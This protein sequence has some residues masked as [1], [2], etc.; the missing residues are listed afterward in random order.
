MFE[1]SPV[2]AAN[3][4]SSKSICVN[5]GGTSS[6]KTYSIL[7]VIFAIL[8]QSEDK[9]CT[10]VGQDIPNLKS[11]AL[12]D[13]LDIYNKSEMLKNLV[14][15]YNKTD[16]IFQFNNGSIVEFKSY[17]DLQDAKS[18]KR[19]YLFV[20]EANGIPYPVYEQ[21]SIRTKIR[22][23]IDYNPNAE[24]W[25]HEH[26]IGK[27]DVQLIIS[28]HRHNKWVPQRIRAQIEGLKEKD[29]EL[30]K[31]YARG[32]TGKIEG[33]IY[34]NWSIV[35]SVPDTAKFIA[36]GMDF[37][38]TNDPTTGIRVYM[39]DGELYLDEILY[40]TGLTNPDIMRELLAK[41]HG[42]KDGIVADSADPKSIREIELGAFKI[43]GAEKGPDSVLNGIDILKRYKINVTRRSQ[44]LRKELLSYKWKVDKISGKSINEPVD[45]FNHALDAV[46][47]VALNKLKSTNRPLKTNF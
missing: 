35:E 29:L 18:G 20:N 42:R 36:L 44:N 47:Y 13:A 5:Q 7:Q 16:R 9:I 39:G 12:R 17:E 31:V 26:L 21:L 2:F 23:F 14:Q 11:G 19:D 32:L 37:G 1:V 33:L 43:E 38:F 22:E 3:Y 28:D 27:P 45:A 6:G 24:F 8:S 46:R 41:G 15:S 4:N 25:V 34:R 30:W 10:V 40:N